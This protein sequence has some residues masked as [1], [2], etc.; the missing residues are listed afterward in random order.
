MSCD[1]VI[2]LKNNKHLYD[3]L[4]K[5]ICLLKNYV[6]TLTINKKLMVKNRYEIHIP[7]SLLR[8]VRK[9]IHPSGYFVDPHNHNNCE[10]YN[11]NCGRTINSN[12]PNIFDTDRCDTSDNTSTSEMSIQT[13]D[14]C[15]IGKRNNTNYH[16]C[17]NDA[18]FCDPVTMK[19]IRLCRKDIL[20][21]I[22]CG[23]DDNFQKSIEQ[24][25]HKYEGFI[26]FFT[27]ISE[28]IDDLDTLKRTL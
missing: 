23:D 15:S 7:K 6:Y 27:K 22:D 13:L 11:S 8:L 5:A 10:H 20:P 18:F 19:T 14:E 9:L 17:L 25:I 24:L 12:S 3:E 4:K 28:H 21:F 26:H 1:C 2:K 16:D